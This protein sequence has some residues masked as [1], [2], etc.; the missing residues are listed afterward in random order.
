[1]I[2]IKLTEKQLV[3]A[4]RVV[5]SLLIILE[6]ENCI[7]RIIGETLRTQMPT[8]SKF[9][10]KALWIEYLHCEQPV[11]FAPDLELILSYM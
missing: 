1:M 7:H 11:L 9:I 6:D 10:N 3:D 8:N 4:V 5:T 2:T